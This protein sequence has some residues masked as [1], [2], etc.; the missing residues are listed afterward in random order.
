MQLQ[1]FRV[2]FNMKYRYLMLTI[3]SIIICS[4]VACDLRTFTRTYTTIEILNKGSVSRISGANIIVHDT[5]ILDG[6]E[7]EKEFANIMPTDQ[8]GKSYIPLLRI[9]NDAFVAKLTLTIQN[10]NLEEIIEI[11]NL[12][13]EV[14]SGDY[15]TVRILSDNSEPPPA[16]TLR[17]IIG[18][19]PIRFE[20][21]GYIGGFGVCSNNTGEE[22]WL[23]IEPGNGNYYLEEIMFGIVPTNYNDATGIRTTSGIIP[24]ACEVN[25]QDLPTDGFTMFASD[26]FNNYTIRSES[27]CIDDLGTV[28]TCN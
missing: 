22:I 17:A 27:Y 12:T 5:I 16:P 18:S 1:N 15:F 7:D 26:P 19:N 21:F 11:N 24:R 28:I 10:E 20:I 9:G 8:N 13:N 4:G 3:I 23:I 14:S 25:V 6:F 2:D